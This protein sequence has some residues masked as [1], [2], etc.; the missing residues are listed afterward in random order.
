MK[1]IYSLLVS[2]SVAIII[3]AGCTHNKT[4]EGFSAAKWSEIGRQAID[5][6]RWNEA[7]NAYDKA[8]ELNPD[9]AS[10]YNNR[11]LAYDHLDKNDLAIADYKKAIELNPKYGDAFNNLG[12]TFSKL[13]DYKRAILYYD[14]AIE[15][16]RKDADAYYN[17][18]NAF[19]NLGNSKYAN[20]DLKI[21]AQLGNILAQKYLKEKG[22]T[23]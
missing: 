5:A 4:I 17:R 8:I 10:A 21:A 3:T 19:S 13:E 14:R 20:D 22:I 7:L 11:G 15:L 9:N 18:G 1:I 23:W 2:L 6:N 16:N 12:K